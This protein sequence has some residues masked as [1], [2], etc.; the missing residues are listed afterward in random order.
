MIPESAKKII[1]EMPAEMHKGKAGKTL[2][3]AGSPGMAGAAALSV[4]GALRSGAGIVKAGICEEI[5]NILQVLNPEAM[6]VSR[7]PESDGILPEMDISEFDSIAAG[8]GLGAGK[9]QYDT[10]IR[11]I[12]EFNGPIVLDADALNSLAMFPENF[13]SVVCDKIKQRTEATVMTPHPGE[14]DRILKALGHE[15]CKVMGRRK[16][17]EVLCERTGA[18]IL[19]KGAGTIVCSP[20]RDEVYINDT[21][22]PGM[23]TGGSGDVLTGVIAS[24]LARQKAGGA[25]G[26]EFDAVVTG[27]LVHGMAGD[28]AADV[29]GQYGM[30][31]G[32]IADNIAKAIKNINNGG[33]NGY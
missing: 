17:A 15:S 12:N 28:I 23:A 3:I 19:M 32:D 18:V 8:P 21:G 31:S 1:T 33:H 29:Y 4:R 2:I 26:D 25:G 11:L 27:A 22:N 10:V 13:S 14:A 24:F 20:D 16:A 30:T 6:C 5:L 7:E 9:K